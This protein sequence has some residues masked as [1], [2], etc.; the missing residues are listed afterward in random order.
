MDS[1]LDIQK[2]NDLFNKLSA[3][4]KSTFTYKSSL[5]KENQLRILLDEFQSP[6]SRLEFVLEKMDRIFFVTEAPGLPPIGNPSIKYKSL[7]PFWCL[8]T[9]NQKDKDIAIEVVQNLPFCSWHLFNQN[10]VKP[11]TLM[12]K[13]KEFFDH[14]VQRANILILIQDLK[15]NLTCPENLLIAPF[16][17]NKD[18]E[19]E[20]EKTAPPKETTEKP[21]AKSKDKNKTQQIEN[22][23]SR[24]AGF[25]RKTITPKQANELQDKNPAPP[26]PPKKNYEVPLV[27]KRYFMIFFGCDKSKVL[28]SMLQH[29]FQNFLVQ[30]RNNIHMYLGL[31][32][33]EDYILTFHAKEFSVVEADYEA[34]EKKF[35]PLAEEILKHR[36]PCIELNVF[37]MNSI[38]PDALN[39]FTK[40]IISAKL[41][42]EIRL[43]CRNLSR[44]EKVTLSKEI[45]EHL[46]DDRS[47]KVFRF[48]LPEQI[49][50]VPVFLMY[51]RQHLLKKVFISNCISQER[52]SL[53]AASTLSSSRNLDNFKESMEDNMM[54]SS[55]NSMI[56]RST[57]SNTIDPIQDHEE[58]HAHLSMKNFRKGIIVPVDKNDYCFL[59]NFL[60]EVNGLTMLEQVFGWCIFLIFINIRYKTLFYRKFLI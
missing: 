13:V 48:K 30:N 1:L 25:S 17:H 50:N 23:S 57:F 40:H 34:S 31:Y 29:F 39:Y 32:E 47:R 51:L 22:F 38:S 27:Y 19:K 5:E 11:D 49:E 8:I 45:T 26:P 6:Q 9:V 2:I 37:S 14:V 59:F 35:E 15:E 56:K 55:K 54:M 4:Q 16:D 7:V 44:K 60:R 18:K 52:E 28:H 43:I 33:K 41:N 53:P 10:T 20:K 21:L 12:M 3:F 24:K 36:N 46:L 58:L 42:E